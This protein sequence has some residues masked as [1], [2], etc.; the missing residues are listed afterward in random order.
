MPKYIISSEQ[1]DALAHSVDFD[2]DGYANADD[3]CPAIANPDQVDRDGN[4]DGDACPGQGL[5]R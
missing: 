3:N 5:G 1:V 4:G 2:G